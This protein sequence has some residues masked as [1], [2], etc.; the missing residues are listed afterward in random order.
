[1]HILAIHRN[2]NRQI[3]LLVLGSIL[4]VGLYHAFSQ[5]ETLINF[6]TALFRVSWIVKLCKTY[7]IFNVEVSGPKLNGLSLRLKVFSSLTAAAFKQVNNLCTSPLHSA[8]KRREHH[9][10]I[11]ISCFILHCRKSLSLETLI[12]SVAV[13]FCDLSPGNSHCLGH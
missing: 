10:V 12:Y 2:R 11:F 8:C 4:H 13:L 3:L 9:Y 5:Q 7:K 1:M 6:V